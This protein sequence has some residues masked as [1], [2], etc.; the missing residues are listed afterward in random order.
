MAN[1][2]FSIKHE[3]N[4]CIG[5]FENFESFEQMFVWSLTVVALLKALLN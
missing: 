4:F 3:I 5:F 2:L 1:I